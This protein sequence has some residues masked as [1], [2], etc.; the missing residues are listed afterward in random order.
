MKKK[1]A[2]IITISRIL[3]SIC[4]LFFPVFSVYFYIMYLFCGLT[5]MADG[6]IARKTKSVSEFGA[7]LDT[8]GDIVFAAVCFAKILPLIKLPA[9]LW[10]WIIA[11]TVI[12]TGNIVSEWI[13][14]KKLLSVHTVL[15]K[16]TGVLLFLFPLTFG[17]IAPVYG[18]VILCSLATVSAVNEAYL[19]W[20]GQKTF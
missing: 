18:A 5:D 15:N 10:I 3:F 9:L 20:K 13:H 7:R 12:K 19:T 11:I 17:I 14:S 16:A 1:I 8:A 6:T 4:M 2:N